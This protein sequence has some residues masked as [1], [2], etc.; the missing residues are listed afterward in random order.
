MGH[1]ESTFIIMGK[2]IVDGHLPYVHMWDLK[3][4]IPFYTYALPQ[5]FFPDSLVA[6]RF[7]GVL[8]IFFSA[9][10]LLNIAR[11]TNIR[12]GFLIGLLYIIFSSILKEVQGVMSEHIAVFFLLLG[13]LFFVKEKNFHNL[14]IAGVWFGCACLCK[15]NLAYPVV[16][17]LIYFFVINIRQTNLLVALKLNTSLVAGLLIPFIIIVMPY[18]RENKMELFINSAFRAPLEYTAQFDVVDKLKNTWKV[19]VAGLVNINSS[20]K[21]FK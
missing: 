7:F 9:L 8:I 12:N 2:S 11:I 4:P 21:I 1:D 20:I 5:Y 10:L 16:G 13:L 6:I 15:T 14:I 17:L 18:V 19:I 3:P